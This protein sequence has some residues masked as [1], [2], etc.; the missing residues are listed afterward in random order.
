MRLNKEVKDCVFPFVIE[1]KKKTRV[2]ITYKKDQDGIDLRNYHEEIL[3]KLTKEN[4]SKLSFA[5]KKGICTKDAVLP[6]N[7]SNLFIKMD[8]KSFF[9]SITYDA[10]LNETK[11][12]FVPFKGI[13]KCFYD[14]HLSLGFV[15]SPKISDI[16]MY[17]FDLKIEEYLKHNPTIKFSRYCDDILISTKSDNFGTLHTFK[18]FIED[19]LNDMNLTINKQKVKEFDFEKQT[20]MSF[21]GLNLVPQDNGNSIITISKPFIVKTLSLIER[22]YE[23]EEQLG[24]LKVDVSNR[25]KKMKNE[26]CEQDYIDESYEIYYK[27]KN[28]KKKRIEKRGII[29][30]RIA[31]I[32][33]NSKYS[34]NRFIK[35]FNNKFENKNIKD[36]TKWQN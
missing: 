33:N 12:Y 15:T 32:K 5:Y 9:E 2:I 22:Y 4:T 19:S 26:K 18:S 27:Y 31:Y 30:S 28:L 11:D 21:L 16:Y 29:L 10:F 23:I 20:S 14:N 17:G 34:Y 7:E 6:H 24:E 3:K 25:W 8:I 13:E 36:L 1:E 35:K